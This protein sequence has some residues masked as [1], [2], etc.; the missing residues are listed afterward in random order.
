MDTLL[1]QKVEF[2]KI[3]KDDPLQIPVSGEIV[4][5]FGTT[6][7]IDSLFLLR[8][9]K[10]FEQTGVESQHVLFWSPVIKDDIEKQVRALIFL[11]PD[12]SLLNE[13]KI[14]EDAFIPFDWAQ[15][16][17][18]SITAEKTSTRLQ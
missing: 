2:K 5:N 6:N 16:S 13:S 4:K 1:G 7:N 18:K 15:L 3:D 14:D 17:Q 12:M 10:S 9:D 11:I 8:L